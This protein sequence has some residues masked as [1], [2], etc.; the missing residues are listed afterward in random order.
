MLI[1]RFPKIVAEKYAFY[2]IIHTF[3]APYE[4]LSYTS[5]NHRHPERRGIRTVRHRQVEG[6]ERRL[7]HP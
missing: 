3:A 4:H 5:D 1:F 7:A 2:T 6:Q